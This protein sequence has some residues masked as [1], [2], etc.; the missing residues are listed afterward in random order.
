MRIPDNMSNEHAEIVRARHADAMTA[1][2]AALA[3]FGDTP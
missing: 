1:L 3:P 2:A